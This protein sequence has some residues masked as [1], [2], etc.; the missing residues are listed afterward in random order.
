MFGLLST[1]VPLFLAV[2]PELNQT[3]E[4]P[5]AAVCALSSE[6]AAIVKEFRLNTSACLYNQTLDSLLRL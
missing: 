6:H 2:R 5:A 1:V 3:E 4:D